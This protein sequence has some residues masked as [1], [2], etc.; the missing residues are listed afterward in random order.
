[1]VRLK[2]I[3]QEVTTSMDFP[4]F[5]VPLKLKNKEDKEEFEKMLKRLK[6]LLGKKTNR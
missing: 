3:I 5:D 2:S 1:M 6:G 4:H